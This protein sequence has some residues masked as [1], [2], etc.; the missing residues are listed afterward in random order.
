MHIH[1]KPVD[2][3]SFFNEQTTVI[4][5]LYMHNILYTNITLSLHFDYTNISKHMIEA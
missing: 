3:V 5:Y 2:T 4:I 1:I